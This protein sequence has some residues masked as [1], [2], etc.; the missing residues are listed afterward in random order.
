MSPLAPEAAPAA[1]PFRPEAAPVPRKNWADLLDRPPLEAAR[2]AERLS[3]N[4]LAGVPE[5]RTEALALAAAAT[6]RIYSHSVNRTAHDDS[7]FVVLEMLTP[8][9]EQMRRTGELSPARAQFLAARL[10]ESARDWLTLA[11]ETPAAGAGVGRGGGVGGGASAMLLSYQSAELLRALAA[12]SPGG[13]IRPQPRLAAPLL[14]AAAAHPLALGPGL[15]SEVL[16][17]AEGA[18]VDAARA[19]LQAS[20]RLACPSAPPTALVEAAAAGLGEDVPGEFG[21]SPWVEAART[22]SAPEA[23]IFAAAV[24]AHPGLSGPAAEAL[25]GRMA[26][27]GHPRV[28]QR[29][30]AALDA[31]LNTLRLRLGR[32]AEASRVDPVLFGAGSP[33]W[34]DPARRLPTVRAVRALAVS[35]GR[36]DREADEIARQT[37]SLAHDAPH[38]FA[39]PLVSAAGVAAALSVSPPSAEA[40]AEARAQADAGVSPSLGARIVARL[41]AGLARA[42]APLGQVARWAQELGQRWQ[43]TEHEPSR[44][45]AWAALTLGAELVADGRVPLAQPELLTRLF[46]EAG[47]GPGISAAAQP[48]A[49]ESA[50]VVETRQSHEALLDRVAT[51]PLP[52]G[53]DRGRQ[54][55]PTTVAFVPGWRLGLCL[56][57][58]ERARQ[59]PGWQPRQAARWLEPAKVAVVAE[60][61]VC[62]WIQPGEGHGPVRFHGES[63][64]STVGIGHDAAEAPM[65]AALLAAAA[66]AVAA[67]QG[68]GVEGRGLAEALGTLG[69]Y[70]NQPDLQRCGTDGRDQFTAEEVRALALG[71]GWRVEAEAEAEAAGVAVETT[72]AVRGRGR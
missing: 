40:A 10:E 49:K 34:T 22:W 3:R 19:A 23:E 60:G 5:A 59:Q 72:A 9:L 17:P 54:I 53:V 56:E 66:V 64:R 28:P 33:A 61:E 67:E 14:V 38:R 36:G 21:Q 27:P 45:Q 63:V 43:Q 50:N 62:G 2:L 48:G 37:L 11:S 71:A 20:S 25:H 69:H 39:G 47:T 24:A 55:V 41:A 46:R 8:A 51:T 16:H 42:T 30:R 13:R 12:L 7:S 29:M 4:A 1:A 70:G 31:S 26:D 18:S 35:V 15:L 68:V 44:R 57:S 6:E 58:V 65:R 52:I 32:T